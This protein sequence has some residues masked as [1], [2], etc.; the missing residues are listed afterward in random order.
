MILTLSINKT[1][2]WDDVLFVFNF[3]GSFLWI[4]L[5]FGVSFYSGVAVTKKYDLVSKK[6]VLGFTWI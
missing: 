4:V 2:R 6:S 1:G 5:L 3:S